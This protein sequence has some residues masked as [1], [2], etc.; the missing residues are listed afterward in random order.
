VSLPG[1][2]DPVFLAYLLPFLVAA[3]ACFLSLPRARQLSDPDTRH[4]LMALLATSGGWAAANAGFLLAPTFASRYVLYVVGLVVGLSTIGPWLY[5]CSA[6]TGRTLHREPRVRWLAVGVFLA[7]VAVKVT[8]PLHELYFTP[9]LETV[10]FVHLAIQYGVVHWVVTGLAYALVAVGYFM[11]FEL[12]LRAGYRTRP[13][14]VLVGLTALPV[15]F[16][17]VGYATPLFIDITYEPIGV[18]A[19]AVGLLFVF[20]ARFQAVQFATDTDDPVVYVDETG[21]VRDYNRPA[22]ELFPVLV[23]ALG[24]PLGDVLP[25]VAAHVDAD[26][27]VFERR[28]DGELRFYRVSSSQFSLGRSRV[29]QLLTVTDVTAAERNRREIRRQ[30][31]RLDQFA[32]V[33]SH[34]LRNPL[35]VAQGR[36]EL[37]RQEHDDDNLVAAADALDRMEAIVEDVLA[38]AREGE[39]VSDPEPVALSTLTD[40]CRES[41][42][43]GDATLE[44]DG[45]LQFRA[46]PERVRRLLENLVRNGLEHAGPD[47]TLTV[48][49]LEDGSGF[50]V[51]DD[52][53]GIP[54]ESREQV[55]E[56]GYTTAEGGTGFGLAIVA[57]IADAHGWTVDVTESATGGARFEVT[58]VDPA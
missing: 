43:V 22:S 18:A 31:E 53:P 38:L 32:S 36:V 12:F 13:L 51:A 39:A 40:R 3:L 11:L 17:I 29:G 30:N 7:I 28:Q 20:G 24:D 46:D 33:V 8:N 56:S 2:P 50:Y 19:F 16:D 10:P 15:A 9:G 4:G 5:F 34:D 14:T 47:V 54:A 21:R 52:G 45:D 55:F 57:E 37:A 42:D 48:G 26:E 41:V 6:Y 35:G 58:G 49:A 1:P 23:D 27:Q 25:T 44:L